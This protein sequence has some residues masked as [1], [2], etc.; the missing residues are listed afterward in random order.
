MISSH[1]V[2]ANE[3]LKLVDKICLSSELKTKQQ[4]CKLLRYL[5]EESLSGKEKN[6]KG[7]NIGVDVYNKPKD[8]D[9]EIDPIVRIHAGRLRRMLKIYSLEAGK[10]DRIRIEIP[11]G[12]YI[13]KFTVN[14]FEKKKEINLINQ[15]LEASSLGPMIAVFPFKNLTGDP[16]KDYFA[17]GFSEELSVELTRFEDLI[18]LNSVSFS[19]DKISENEKLEFIRKKGV[20]FYVEGGINQT[21]DQL[22]IL[23]R[24][25]DV[26]NETQIW[27]ERYLRTLNSEN[28]NEIQEAIAHEISLVIG[29]EYGLILQMLSRDSLDKTP[30]NSDIYDAIYRFHYFEAIQSAEAS[31]QAFSAL[32]QGLKKEPN[33]GIAT[34]FLAS[35]YGTMYML[36]YP[37]YENADKQLALLAERAI[38]LAPYSLTARIIVLF[39]YFAFNEKK[40]FFTE[41]EKCLA[42]KPNSPSRL[43]SIGNFLS[44]YGDWARGKALLDKVMQWNVNFPHYY[45]G[46]TTLYYYRKDEYEKA[47]A[48][49]N[50]YDMPTLFW[51]PLLRIATF[52]QLNN[53]S[54]ARKNIIHLKKLKPD[55]EK[56]S[57]LLISRY[58]KEDDLVDHIVEGLK[59]A[60][61]K[62]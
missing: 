54:E 44:L 20:R 36:D 47:L 48:Q 4:L 26:F 2:P 49:A 38:K 17:L 35:M 34:A 57:R 9:P 56:K 50:Q 25:I 33:S 6:I 32:E 46:A 18:V 15:K 59:K 52:G 19:G 11:K 27:A 3:V 8:F 53:L 62:L 1:K 37:N 39:K 12:K 29:S 21:G 55:F 23:V 10:N 58:V 43:G 14:L 40:L 22:K 51:A 5:V 28:L 30:I 45:F 60:G 31:V 61:M 16:T 41:A 42:M 13:P 24:L 7:Y